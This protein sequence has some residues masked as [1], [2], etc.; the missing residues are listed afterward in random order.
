[1]VPGRTEITAKRTE[2][3]EKTL[4]KGVK[5]GRT[6]RRNRNGL[7]ISGN[8][9]SPPKT[10]LANWLFWWILKNKKRDILYRDIFSFSFL[11]FFG[12]LLLSA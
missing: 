7:I 8:G 9:A 3:S 12:R 2:G 11:S 10:R 1:M 6:L 4:T 5:K